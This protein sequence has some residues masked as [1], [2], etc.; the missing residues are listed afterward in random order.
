MKGIGW[1][2]LIITF[3]SIAAVFYLKKTAGLSAL[4]GEIVQLIFELDKKFE[5]GE[6]YFDLDNGGSATYP[7]C[8]CLTE[9]N[10][11]PKDC[12]GDVKYIYNNIPGTMCV[13]MNIGNGRCNTAVMSSASF[14]TMF[15]IPL[16]YSWTKPI[17]KIVIGIKV[18][19]TAPVGSRL[20]VLVNIFKRNDMGRL[21][22]YKQYDRSIRVKEPV[23]D[24]Q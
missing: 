9:K 4:K 19:D 22:M 24:Q 6:Y 23:K 1:I 21:V 3:L 7:L 18:P 16:E 12:A 20:V 15:L 17:E 13:P 5:F 10:M 2:V 14:A 11:F 8:F